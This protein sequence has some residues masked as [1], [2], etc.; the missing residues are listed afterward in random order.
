MDK[1]FV[2][3]DRGD[4][5]VQ[6]PAAN[7]WGFSLC[8]DE[9]SWPGGFGIARTWEVIDEFDPRISNEAHQRLD[10]LFKY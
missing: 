10:F 6:V 2:V 8:D 9:L 3:T 7:P 1:S 4:V 5:L